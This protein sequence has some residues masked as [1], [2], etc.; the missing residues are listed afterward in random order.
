MTPEGKI[1]KAIK[2]VLVGHGAYQYWPVPTGFGKSGLDCYC[3]VYGAWFVIEAKAPGEVPTKR[4]QECARDIIAAGGVALLI[5]TKQKVEKFETMCNRLAV[6]KNKVKYL[7]LVEGI[8]H[9]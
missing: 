5:D 4:Q 6:A 3:C 8:S 1:K 2:L 7:D 9:E